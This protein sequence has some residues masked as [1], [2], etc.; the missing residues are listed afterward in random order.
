MPNATQIKSAGSGKTKKLVLQ[1]HV[2]PEIFKKFSDSLNEFA[3]YKRQE[4]NVPTYRDSEFSSL[5]IQET[6]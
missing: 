3:G 2:Y 4:K 5:T 1:R 6:A